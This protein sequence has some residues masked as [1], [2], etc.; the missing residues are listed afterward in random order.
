MINGGRVSGS[1]LLL[2]H[3]TTIMS[4]A[5]CPRK[6]PN[7]HGLGG[8]EGIP[9]RAEHDPADIWYTA[10]RDPAHQTHHRGEEDA[11]SGLAPLVLF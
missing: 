6:F 2:P 9:S 7:R 3:H 4:L 1:L 11:P 8:W 5:V 10:T